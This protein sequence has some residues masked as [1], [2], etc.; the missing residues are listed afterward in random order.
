M[1]ILYWLL[2]NSW[3]YILEGNDLAQSQFE[4]WDA[5]GTMIEEIAVILKKRKPSLDLFLMEDLS[6]FLKNHKYV[7]EN[8]YSNT[9]LQCGCI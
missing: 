9:I 5:A 8:S 2:N 7:D 3:F 1:D 6:R 4:D